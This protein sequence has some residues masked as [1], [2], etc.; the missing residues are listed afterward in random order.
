MTD[1]ILTQIIEQVLYEMNLLNETNS[2]EVLHRIGFNHIIKEGLIKT[3]D[4]EKTIQLISRNIN[5]KSNKIIVRREINSTKKLGDSYSIS[6]IFRSNTLNN[7]V[8]QDII[9]LA[10]LCGWYLS[11]IFYNGITYNGDLGNFINIFNGGGYAFYFDAK[12]DV[13][14]SWDELPSTLY[15]ATLSKNVD[16]IVKNG[17]FPKSKSNI[18]TYPSRVYFSYNMEEA[19]N[20]VK[21]KIMNMINNS[22]YNNNDNEIGVIQLDLTKLRHDYKF[23]K[24]SNSDFDAVYTYEPIP[25]F[26][27][28]LNK[29][30]KL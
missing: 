5:L 24:D 8:I 10:N 7:G 19:I 16:N 25:F 6:F 11:S 29:I 2:M 26:S 15:H 12:F 23:M 18:S 1:S 4:C 20:F 17:L 22:V 30:I 21:N 9:R 3:E 28:S 14:I 27:L 13:E